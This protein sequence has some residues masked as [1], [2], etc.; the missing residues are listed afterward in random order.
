MGIRQP[1]DDHIKFNVYS[2]F[3]KEHIMLTILKPILLAF[4][5]SNS[6][7]KLIIQLL[8]ALVQQSSNSL[9]D[10]AVEF[11]KSRLYPASNT[12]LQ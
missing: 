11:I 10:Q 4:I 9:D 2:M 7:K 3:V 8:E 1:I 6:M 5:K 12:K